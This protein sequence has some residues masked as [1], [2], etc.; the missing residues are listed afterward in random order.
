MMLEKAFVF[1]IFATLFLLSDSLK[2]IFKTCQITD[3]QK[4]SKNYIFEGK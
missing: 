3:K 2:F 1:I 4:D